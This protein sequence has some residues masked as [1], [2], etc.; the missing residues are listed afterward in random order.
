VSKI[1]ILGVGP[2]NPALVS[3]LVKETAL[4]CHLLLGGRR[5]LKIFPD[6]KGEKKVIEGKLEP[7]ME[8]IRE[9]FPHKRIGILV[10]GD[11]GLYSLLPVVKG[12]FPPELLEVV[13]GISALQYLFARLKL[14]WHDASI[15]SLHGKDLRGLSEIVRSHA[16]VGIFTDPLRTPAAVCRQLL[17]EGLEKR[18]VYVGENLSYPEER[19]YALTLQE[20]LNLETAELNV[21]VILKEE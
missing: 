17:E 21:M 14:P 5:N 2:G 7:L 11:P 19:I 9:N 18:R 4:S 13:P 3:P 16:K 15:L 6:F 12:Y 8:L 1:F 10:S 20:C